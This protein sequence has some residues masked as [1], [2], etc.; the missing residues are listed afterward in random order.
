MPRPRVWWLLGPALAGLVAFS[1]P[2]RSLRSYEVQ[3][4]WAGYNDVTATDDCPKVN[5]QGYDSLIGTVRGLEPDGKTDDDVVYQGVLRRTTRLDTC[6]GFGK[7]PQ[8][9]RRLRRLRHGT[10]PQ[11]VSQRSKRRIARRPVYSGERSTQILRC[12]RTTAAR[13]LLPD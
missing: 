7:E 1:T 9:R 3:F 5:K 13:R 8:G 4:G 2:H 10:D 11:G 12:G 6:D